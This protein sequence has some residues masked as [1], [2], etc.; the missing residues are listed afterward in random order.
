MQYNSVYS[1]TQ[2]SWRV[3]L[4]GGDVREPWIGT[5]HGVQMSTIQYIILNNE[6]LKSNSSIFPWGEGFITQYTP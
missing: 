6:I 1:A 5:P 2:S 4:A 3:H